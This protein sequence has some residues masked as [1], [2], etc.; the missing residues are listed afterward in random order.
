MHERRWG[1]PTQ[2]GKCGLFAR[3][4]VTDTPLSTRVISSVST[5]RRRILSKSAWVAGAMF[6]PP[7]PDS[8]VVFAG[9][10]IGPSNL[11]QVNRCPGDDRAHCRPI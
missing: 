7:T 1:R 8:P 6:P 5:F 3:S 9:F 4:D 2:V 10:F 11:G